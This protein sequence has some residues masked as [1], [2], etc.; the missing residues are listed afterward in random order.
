MRNFQVQ[1]IRFG[2]LTLLVMA[3]VLLPHLAFSQSSYPG[4][5]T[6][7]YGY[8]PGYYGSSVCPRDPGAKPG[9]AVV[10]LHSS[11]CYIL[12]GSPAAQPVTPQQKSVFEPGK[13]AF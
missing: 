2:S 7:C 11:Y 6:Y 4:V 12:R 8:N 13:R 3:G 1:Y 9:Q 5:Y 10:P